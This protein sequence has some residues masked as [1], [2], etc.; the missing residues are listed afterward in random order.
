MVTDRA[1]S[2]NEYLLGTKSV[3]QAGR[4]LQKALK[5]KANLSKRNSAITRLAE[6]G[7]KHDI[8]TKNYRRFMFG[9]KE[10]KE[11]TEQGEST[12]VAENL[13]VNVVNDL[14][15]ASVYIAAG[16]NLGETNEEPKP[17]LL[18][19][20]L[21]R[22]GQTTTGLETFLTGSQMQP[23]GVV[24]YGLVETA[25][26]VE[27][28]TSSDMQSAVRTFKSRGE[29]T[30][31]LIVSEAEDVV[32]TLI[33]DLKKLLDKISPANVLAILEGLGGPLGE[34]PK[35]IGQFI[36]LGIEKIKS[37]MK[38]VN[39]VLGSDILKK[40]SAEVAELWKEITGGGLVNS[41]LRKVFG[42]EETS[43]GIEEILKLE[44]LD[45]GK[46]DQGTKAL[47]ELALPYRNEMAMA[48]KAV[49]AISLSVAVL[50]VIPVAGTKVALLA[51][52]A[53]G[54]VLSLVVLDGM[55]YTGSRGL[56][57]RVHGV[58]EITDS[59]RPSA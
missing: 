19:D 29:E 26:P 50:L 3:L 54:L 10:E 27:S 13:F 30:L 37:V 22:L 23:T 49:K 35:L 39:D 18:D 46:V 16:Q 17:Y 51:A 59:L 33:D 31:Q 2:T 44:S 7:Q 12:D 5:T 47:A 14:E 57:T 53:Y 38:T 4:E 8:G 21:N 48:K 25:A 52:T 36:Q 42:V 24:R 56:L 43:G 41:L 1:G 6:A 40:F 28:L 45:K 55:D 58:S 32:T 15:V 9:E 20:A 11:T 34:A